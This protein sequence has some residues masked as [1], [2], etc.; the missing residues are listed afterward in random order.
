MLRKDGWSAA[1]GLY[2]NGDAKKAGPLASARQPC[3]RQEMRQPRPT[4]E[5]VANATSTYATTRP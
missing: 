2:R 3:P 5:S 1:S 4:G